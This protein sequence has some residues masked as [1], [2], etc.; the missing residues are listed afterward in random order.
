MNHMNPY[1]N[2]HYE[3]ETDSYPLLRQ[4]LAP[5]YASLPAE[6]LEA[7]IEQTFGPV[8]TASEYEEIFGGLGKA[9]SSFGRDIG[10]AAS[11]AGHAIWASGEDRGSN[12][13]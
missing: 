3:R 1:R 6:R 8:L 11:G 12:S 4:V 2:F 7:V 13:P 10:G 5:D 9:F